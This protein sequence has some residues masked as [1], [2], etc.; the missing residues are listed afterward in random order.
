MLLC[1]YAIVAVVTMMVC[2]FRPDI[3]I[4]SVMQRAGEIRKQKIKENLF[5][6]LKVSPV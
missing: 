5:E 6:C 4:Q 1:I 2:G 3:T